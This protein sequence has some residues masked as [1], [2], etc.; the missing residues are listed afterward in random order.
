MHAVMPAGLSTSDFYYILPEL[1]L[2]GGALLVLIADVLLPRGSKALGWIT[3]LVIGATAASL[4]PFTS[5]HVEVA[6]G[7]LAVDRFALFFKVLFLGAAAITVLMS[8]KYLE[9]EH[10]SPGEYYFLILCSTLGMMVMAGCVDLISLFLR[11]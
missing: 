2:T 7:L 8:M 1:V 5:T 6:H 3:L 10:V 4:A 11:L 9:I